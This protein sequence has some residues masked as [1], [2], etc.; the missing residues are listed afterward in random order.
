LA[1]T[2][3]LKALALDSTLAEAHT[4]LARTYETLDWNFVA[5]EREY[6]TAIA[7]EPRYALAHEWYG[8]L[9]WGLGRYDEMLQQ[10][11]IGLQL[12]PLT[13]A[14]HVMMGNALRANRRYSEAAQEYRKSI[15]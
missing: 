6:R 11:T 12:E 9:L 14:N 1:Q 2:A 8:I 4:S 3:A 13:A 7:L 10:K 15:E 5:A